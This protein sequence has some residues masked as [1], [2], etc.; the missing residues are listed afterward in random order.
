MMRPELKIFKQFLNAQTALKDYTPKNMVTTSKKE[1]DFIS[2]YLNLDSMTP[3]ELDMMKD[4]VVLFYEHLRI[5]IPREDDMWFRYWNSMM[6]V[7][8]IINYVKDKKAE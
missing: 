7:T 5:G 2:D 3:D 4:F 6:S 1:I 8:A